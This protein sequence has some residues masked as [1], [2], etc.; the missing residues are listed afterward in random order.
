M[1]AVRDSA[2][3]K[4]R[5]SWEEQGLGWQSEIMD[6]QDGYKRVIVYYGSRSYD[7]KQMFAL[8]D[9]LIQDAQAL[10]IETATPEE[11]AKM[12]GLLDDESTETGTEAREG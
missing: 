5:K 6:S 9:N 1:I 7:T 2:V 3:E 4:F 11:L 12:K 10:G 8:I